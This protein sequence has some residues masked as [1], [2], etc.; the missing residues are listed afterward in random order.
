MNKVTKII[1]AGGGSSGWIAASYIFKAL[2]FNVD[3]TVIE[4]PKIP[5]IG[6]GEA[7]IP[8]IKEELFDFLQIP[9]KE[10]MP[11]C[12][13]TYKLGIKFINWK[14]NASEGGDHYY[15]SFGEMPSCQNIPLSQIWMYHRHKGLK[16][17]HDY[18]CYVTPAICDEYKSPRFLDD[19]KVVHYAYHF[20]ALLIA[21]FLQDWCVER[22]LNHI[23]DEIVNVELNEEGEIRSLIGE[24]GQ[25]YEADLYIDCTGFA[26]LLIEKALK[27]PWISFSDCL[28]TDSAVAINIPSDPGIEGIRPYTTATAFSSGWQ[29]EIPLFGRSGN[30]YV[31][32]SAFQSADEAEKEMR[33]FFGAKVAGLDA[34][35]IKFR[36]GR[37]R[38]SWVKNCISFGLASSFLEPLESTGLY[39]VYAA[40][41]QFMEYFPNKEIDPVLR[42]KFNEKAA[43]MV[44]DVRD[45]IVMH[46]C[47]SPREDTAFWRAN[48]HELKIP[49][50]LQRILSLQKAGIPIKKSYANNEFLYASFEAGFDR[51][52]TNSNYQCVLAGVGY[53]P[54]S[55]LPLLNHR[56]D[57]LMEA[58]QVFAGIETKSKL[59]SDQLPTQ[60][61]YLNHIYNNAAVLAR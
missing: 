33:Q 32:S 47:T 61:E 46:F 45:F 58:E 35:H 37:R 51:F 49:E 12:K 41:Y 42:D 31:Y 11:V 59:L 15:H 34:R 9:E 57:I 44:E 18:S 19:T 1:I 16:K 24:N 54:T 43:Y 39:F 29:W 21:N 28:L 60:Y 56:A 36:S 5:K 40:L 27:E 55:Y 6:V 20:D 10:W 8:T 48:K 52:W 3:I 50:S 30:G 7:T 17:P 2:N 4:S 13:G 53:L 38:R 25:R 26:G 22:G 23:K 14:R